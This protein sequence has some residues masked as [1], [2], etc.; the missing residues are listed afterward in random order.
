MPKLPPLILEIDILLLHRGRKMPG[1]NINL[2]AISELIFKCLLWSKFP[3]FFK[4]SPTFAFW[5]NFVRENGKKKLRLTL[6]DTLY[7]KIFIDIFLRGRR[8]RHTHTLSSL[9][10]GLL[11]SFP[12]VLVRFYLVHRRHNI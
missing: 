7:N 1:G 12:Q 8:T 11:E 4:T 9:L 2:S 3:E 5:M 6:W 10:L